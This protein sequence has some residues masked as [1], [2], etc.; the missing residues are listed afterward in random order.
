MNYFIGVMLDKLHK[1]GIEAVLIKGQGVAQCYA[2]PEWRSAGDVDLL[3]NEENYEKGKA[4]LNGISKTDPKQYSFNKEFITTIGGW[5]L[6]LH[7]SLKCGQS[8]AINKEIDAIQKGRCDNHHVRY[9]GVDGNK[10]PLPE[11]NE[12]VMVIFTHFIKHFYKGG[13]GIRQICDWCRLLWTYRSTIDVVLLEKRLRAM[14]LMSEWKA[15]AAY[16]VEYLGMPKEAMPLYSTDRKW[17]RK[18]EK[19]H[20]FI[21]K[22]GNFG[23]NEDGSYFT[24][25]PF[26]IRKTISMFRRVGV[27]FH[28]SRI[29]P[30]STIKFMPHVLFIGLW[31]AAKGE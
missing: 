15:F 12:D 4:F 1:A 22:V 31:S 23:H 19:I 30:M 17:I 16:A 2:K 14:G 8:A 13:L 27:L 18:S 29:F 24:K 6:E 20:D 26:L 3:L 11:E 7:G 25:Y 5:C 28:H 9:W 21:V 10:I